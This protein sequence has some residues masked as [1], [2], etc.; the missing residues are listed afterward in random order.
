MNNEILTIV[1]ECFELQAQENN[2]TEILAEKI[3]TLIVK[4]FNKLIQILYRADISEQKLKAMLAENTTEDA[5]KIIGVLFIQ[6]QMQKIRSRQD[7]RR[8][9]NNI[10]EDERW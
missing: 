4:D 3:N 2:F 6:R 9:H 1:N 5:G 7:N 10:S 8:D